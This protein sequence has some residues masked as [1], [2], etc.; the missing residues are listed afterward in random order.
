[1]LVRSEERACPSEAPALCLGA[2]QRRGYRGQ[3]T[4]AQVG[5]RAEVGRDVGLLF[6]EPGGPVG[7]KAGWG[8]GRGEE[9]GGGAAG[10]SGVVC[11]RIAW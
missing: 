4:T 3:T 10:V 6:L 2:G 9:R 5:A 1:M 8:K 11:R 7:E